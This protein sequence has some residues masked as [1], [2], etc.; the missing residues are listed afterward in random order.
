MQEYSSLHRRKNS[1]VL[2]RSK[3]NY[4]H[5]Q[6][7]YIHEKTKPRQPRILY[8]I[9]DISFLEKRVAFVNT[10]DVNICRFTRINYHEYKY[11]GA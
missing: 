5:H 9:N 11:E 10:F 6:H 8:Q 2:F 7:Y 3:F 1:L 4:I